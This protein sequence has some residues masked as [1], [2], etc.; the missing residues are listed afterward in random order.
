MPAAPHM[1]LSFLV[2]TS[3]ASDVSPIDWTDYTYDSELG[4]AEGVPLALSDADRVP[5][6]EPVLSVKIDILLLL[7]RRIN[8]VFF[9]K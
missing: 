5:E 8:L 3:P 7:T 9:A 6:G 1:L 2:M 4:I